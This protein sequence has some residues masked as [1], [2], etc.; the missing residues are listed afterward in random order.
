V[1]EAFEINY[2]DRDHQFLKLR[3]D[4]A[5]MEVMQDTGIKI[6]ALLIINK[7]NKGDKEYGQITIRTFKQPLLPG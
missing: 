2:L 5:Q 4:N 6:T 3:R 1:T 7:D